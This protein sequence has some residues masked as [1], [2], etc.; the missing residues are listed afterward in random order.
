[1]L[2]D[3]DV[4]LTR[5]DIASEA[6]F[7]MFRYVLWTE[8]DGAADDARYEMGFTSVGGDYYYNPAYVDADRLKEFYGNY[9]SLFET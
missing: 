8:S 9:F 6:N 3:Y 5:M 4:A 1:V 7:R 2:E